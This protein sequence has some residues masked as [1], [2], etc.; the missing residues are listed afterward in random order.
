MDRNENGIH[1]TDG[2]STEACKSFPM[3]CGQWGATFKVYFNKFYYTK[4]NKINMCH[5]DVQSM[6][7]IQGHTKDF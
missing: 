5:S 2:W 4:C 3:H 1:R 6:F 7:C